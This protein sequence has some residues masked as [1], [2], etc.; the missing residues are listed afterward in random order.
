MTNRP[1]PAELDPIELGELLLLVHDW[2]SADQ[3]AR[4]SFNQ[5][6][7]TGTYTADDLRSDLL[8]HIVLLGI[9]IG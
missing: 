6:L 5:F 2:I 7:T 8:R 9:D 3:A 4:I 1:D